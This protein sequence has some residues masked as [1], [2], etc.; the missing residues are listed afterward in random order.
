MQRGALELGNP[1]VVMWWCG[2]GVV[3]AL[4]PDVVGAW[5]TGVSVVA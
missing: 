1:G 5:R 4:L 3:P 2:V